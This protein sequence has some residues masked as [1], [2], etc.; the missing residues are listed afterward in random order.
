MGSSKGLSQNSS[1][2][3]L[4]K[5]SAHSLEGVSWESTGNLL[6]VCWESAGSPLGV[7]WE[8]AEFIKWSLQKALHEL[9]II[10]ILQKLFIFFL[11]IPLGIYNAYLSIGHLCVLLTP[12][13][14]AAKLGPGW[15][16]WEHIRSLLGVCWE[17]DFPME[18]YQI[19]KQL[20][21]LGVR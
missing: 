6:G 1:P 18:Y 20:S 9:T 3:E 5:L 12:R 10:W 11:F 8:S 15:V 14:E 2:Y 13:N 4:S 16:C 19:L 7:C 21:P 17:S